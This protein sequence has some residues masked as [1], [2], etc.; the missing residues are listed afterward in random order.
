MRADLAREEQTVHVLLLNWNGWRD[1]IECLESVLRLE[2]PELRVIVCDNGSTD[3]SEA[4][5]AEWARG[6]LD[7]PVPTHPALAALVTPPVRKPIPMVRYDRAAAERGG[8]PE[9][10]R[11]H[12]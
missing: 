5:I 6:A 7:A 11:A 1:T 12:V 2:W 8:D 10:G 4:R 9:I 3:G